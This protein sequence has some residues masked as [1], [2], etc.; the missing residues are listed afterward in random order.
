VRAVEG[1]GGRIL[2]QKWRLAAGRGKSLRE[3]STHE[4]DERQLD[5]GASLR[6]LS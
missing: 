4:K 1:R 2:N 6:R 3:G 5:H